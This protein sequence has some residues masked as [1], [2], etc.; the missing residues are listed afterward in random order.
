MPGRFRELL[1]SKAEEEGKKVVV[2]GE[3]Y[4]S[5]TCSG[6]GWIDDRLGGKKLF[7]CR[8]GCGLVIDR[9]NVRRP[10]VCRSTTREGQPI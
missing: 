5:K 10:L 2:V 3:A 9:E 7:K 8:G 1:I 6:C 4:T